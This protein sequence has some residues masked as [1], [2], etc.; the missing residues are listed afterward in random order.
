ML[1]AKLLV[2]AYANGYFPM[3]DIESDEIS[4]YR[5]DPRAILPLDGFH[6]SRSLQRSL[7]KNAW[8]VTF[9]TAFETI[10]RACGNRSETWIT[11]EFV[12]AYGELHE[13]GLGHSVEV[14][15]GDQL[16]GGAYGL[17]LGAAFFAE[18]KFHTETDASKAALY[19]LVERLRQ[20]QFQ[21][22]EVQFLT[23]HLSTLG[24]IE[25]SATEYEARLEKALRAP[26]NF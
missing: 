14:W 7:R 22:F 8:T 20:N 4:W 12:R 15:R 1:T 19:F 6:L 2:K 24:A 13:A 26:V 16:V 3:G 10:M 25:I 17:S 9:D 21:L 23:S 18:S 5:P 11:E